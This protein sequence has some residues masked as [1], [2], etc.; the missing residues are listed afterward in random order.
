MI[1]IALLVAAALV[2][3][4]LLWVLPSPR[5]RAVAQF[6]KQS[7]QAGFSVKFVSNEDFNQLF[8]GKID[9]V[10]PEYR[11][12]IVRYSYD[13]NSKQDD[14]I[15]SDDQQVDPSNI[16]LVYFSAEA[17]FG[18]LINNQRLGLSQDDPSLSPLI[19]IATQF[20]GLKAIRL[21]K[22]VLSLYWLEFGDPEDFGLSVEMAQT[23]QLKLASLDREEAVEPSKEEE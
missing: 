22:G 23:L 15:G 3:G 11:Q 4:S 10:R 16:S 18:I 6:R 20:E 17:L 19:E 5:A 8:K 2:L 14:R 9:R 13:F 1:Y 21:Y 12:Q 7:I